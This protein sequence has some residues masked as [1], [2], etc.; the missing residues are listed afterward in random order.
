VIEAM[1]AAI[2]DPAA[3]GMPMVPAALGSDA[4]VIGAALGAVDPRE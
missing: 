4:A 3:R 1:R 2:Y